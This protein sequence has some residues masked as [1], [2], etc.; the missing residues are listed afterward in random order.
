MFSA[1]TLLSIFCEIFATGVL[2]AGGYTFSKKYKETNDNQFL[3]LVAI[4][5]FFS[6]YVIGV[7]VSQILFDIDVPLS[8]LITIQRL[9]HASLIFAAVFVWLFFFKMAGIKARFLA[10][11]LYCIAAVLLWLNFFSVITLVFRLDIIEPFI[12]SVAIVPIRYFWALSWLCLSAVYFQKLRKLKNEKEKNLDI[13]RAV[14]SLFVFVGYL[15]AVFYLVSGEGFFLLLSWTITFFSFFGVLLGFI[16][17]ADDEI[18][19]RPIDYLKTRILFKLIILFIVMIVLIVE[20]MTLF[21][22]SMSRS[23]LS[24][25]VMDNEHQIAASVAEKAAFYLQKYPMKDAV[26]FLQ[27]YIESESAIKKQ[28]IFIVDFKKKIVAHPDKRRAALKEDMS[29]ISAVDNVAMNKSGGEIF[30]DRSGQLMVASYVPI[31]DQSMGIIV[32]LPLREAYSE[33]RK[34]ETNSLIFVIAGIM[35]AASFGIFFAKSIESPIND[36]IYGTEQVRK[37]NLNYRISTDAIDEVGRLA[38]AFNMMT[39]E[40]KESQNHLIASEKLAALGTMAAG[41]AHEIKNPLVALKTFTQIL[42]LKWDDKEFREKFITVLPPEIDKINRIAENLL[43]FG[44]PSRPEFKPV[45]VNTILEEVLELLENQL[46]KN[47]IRISTKFVNIPEIN[48]DP[49]QLS[50]SFLNIVLNAVQAMPN[51]GELIIKTDQGQVIQLGSL[52][53]SGFV[54]T[55]KSENGPAGKISAVFIEITDTGSGIPE[56]TMKNMFDPFY[57]TKSSGTGMGLP[58]TLRI[59]EEHKGT[60]KVRSQLGKGTTFIIMLP[61]ET[62]AKEEGQA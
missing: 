11:A 50:Q 12:E 19:R 36:V 27:S 17:S 7:V 41:M 8:S 23:Y 35:I 48:G 21:T 52:T 49:S 51:G 46:K 34:V 37:G 5:T 38:T 43:K 4:F 42:P 22:I 28:T 26:P 15:I 57:T 18:A 45:N 14:S 53:K 47:N 3:L 44:K 30:I 32:S 39:E 31:L 1:L 20:S 2:I 6:V 59:I 62:T 16:L 10:V 9:I 25:V 58:I 13:L 40:L 55:K 54:S 24:K 56:E 29:G 33:I 60:I 61:K